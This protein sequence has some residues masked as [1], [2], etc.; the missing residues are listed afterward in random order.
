MTGRTRQWVENS[1]K[2]I[3]QINTST[4]SFKWAK[5]NDYNNQTKNMEQKPDE[6]N[7]KEVEMNSKVQTL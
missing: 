3:G 4:K 1:L 5:P 2:T 7:E 6:V